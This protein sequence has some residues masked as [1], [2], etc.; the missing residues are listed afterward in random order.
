MLPRASFILMCIVCATPALADIPDTASE[1][2]RWNPW[3]AATAATRAAS[4]IDEE[5]AALRQANLRRQ[6]I[7]LPVVAPNAQIA[8]AAAAHS[9][10]LATHNLTGHYENASQYPA[11]FTGITPGNRLDAAH[12]GWSTYSEVIS[13]G[14]PT[15]ALAVES[16]IQA[17][18][19]RFG[20][21][22]PAVNEAG[23]GFVDNHPA[24]GSMLTLDLGRRGTLTDGIP[25][26]WVGVYPAAGQTGVPRDFY[27]DEESPDPVPGVN[28]VGYPVSLHVGHALNLTVASFTLKTTGGQNIPVTRLA[29]ATDT[30]TPSSAAAIIPTQPL[31]A[32]Q[33]YTASFSGSADGA[34]VTMNWSFTTTTDSALRFAPANP[35][36]PVGIARTVYLVGATAQN[37]GWSN[38]QV[39]DVEFS[40]TD[41]LRVTGSTVG[42]ASITVTDGDDRQTATT[43]TVAAS[44]PPT[45][46]TSDRL[47]DWAE[48]NFRHVLE[49]PGQTSQSASGYYYR[50]YPVTDTYLGTKDGQIW[51]LDA[52]SGAFGQVGDIDDY[53]P[54]VE[55]DGY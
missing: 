44:C 8:A 37:V 4:P 25:S 31:A 40:S 39:V 46:S 43:V 14:P 21:F 41:S 24:Y 3:F 29:A 54:Q 30:H 50:Y 11:G 12:Y 16:L 1:K 10:Y 33:A 48:A 6:Q 2:R 34:T 28:R 45:A 15:G 18:Y 51:F 26:G 7:G 38:A 20:L 47:F 52:Y 22:A 9:A 13:A 17:I 49:P 32:G 53:L 36:I 19:H 5:A 23:A 35:C 27:S 42:T 55:A